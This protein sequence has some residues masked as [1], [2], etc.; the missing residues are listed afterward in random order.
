M[1]DCQS[2]LKKLRRQLKNNEFSVIGALVK[3]IEAKDSYTAG[4]GERVTR[5]AVD[6]A[7]WL[8]YPKDRILLLK[9]AAS[10]H[11]IGKIGVPE[12]IL[13][14]PD[15]LTDEEFDI[16]RKHPQIGYDAIKDINFLKQVGEIILEHHE[17]F[18]G[19]GYPNG[20][21]GDEINILS[22]LLAICD[23]YDAMTSDRAYRKK[24]S[25]QDIITELEKAK[26]IQF[27]P[28]LAGQ[29]ISWISISNSPS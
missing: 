7:T 25:H 22:R 26:G 15:R 21:T 23:A 8:N 27:D 6:F 20:L 28:E 12:N 24:L 16:I 4:H 13:N 11:D 10:L 17:W 2:E 1:E 9:Y 29:F 5:L 19:K 3:L 14:K 18:N